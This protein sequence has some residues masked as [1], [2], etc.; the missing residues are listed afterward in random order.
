MKGQPA[1]ADMTAYYQ[2]P[3]KWLGGVLGLILRACADM[4]CITLQT[5]RKDQHVIFVSPGLP[6]A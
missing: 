6:R 4:G 3:L 5:F 1:R 2:R